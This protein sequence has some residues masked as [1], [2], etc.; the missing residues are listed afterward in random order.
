MDD[1]EKTMKMIKNGYDKA[2]ILK[3][4]NDD[5]YELAYSRI[6]AKHKLSFSERVYADIIGIQT[7][8]P[9]LIAEYKAKR[10]K[11]GIIADLSCGI[12]IQSLYFSKFSD[13]VYAFDINAKRLEYAKKN[14]KLFN[15]NNIVFI[16]RS[17][18]DAESVS[19]AKDADIIFSDPARAKNQ[20]TQ[21][22][23]NLSPDPIE[24]LKLYKDNDNIAF[25]IP[26]QI[27]EDRFKFECEKEFVSVNGEILR[28][29]IY[30]GSLRECEKSA[31]ILPGENRLCY[32][33]NVDRAFEIA[34]NV[35]SYIYE[36]DP[37]ITYAFLVPEIIKRYKLN[38]L[39]S[40]KKRTLGTLD[41]LITSPFFKHIFIV[42]EICDFNNFTIKD[43]LLKNDARSVILKFKISDSE[44]WPFRTFLEK[45]LHG[46]RI[47]YL[48]KLLD[49]AVLAE[50]VSLK[51]I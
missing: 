46:S 14:A 29:S 45:N 15:R 39:E 18:Y 21:Q 1:I 44:Y 24:I 31:M 40:S 51:T 26:V 37:A 2:H 12:G 16:N 4:V 41:S 10:L 20:I 9:E 28:Q 50:L 42:R 38:I 32:D 7:A 3:S 43:A 25:D 11:T 22:L 33:H 13:M 17:A 27:P 19:F 30:F 6:L 47:L 36:I 8:T 35:G 23:Q 34:E 48:F 49:K 5:I